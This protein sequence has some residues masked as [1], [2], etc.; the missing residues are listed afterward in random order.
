MNELKDF[1]NKCSG[2]R[3]K[4]SQA[5][6]PDLTKHGALNKLKQIEKG[7]IE[8]PANWKEK[9]KEKGYELS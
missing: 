3:S 1:I 7:K 6:F 4:V 9:L 2:I 5:L 8:L